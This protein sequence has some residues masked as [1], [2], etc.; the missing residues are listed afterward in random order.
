MDNEFSRE[1]FAQN[2]TLAGVGYLVF[3]VPL[4]WCGKSRLGRYCANQGLLLMIVQLLV[5]ILFTIFAGI[6]LLGWLFT[7]AGR[8]VSLALVVVALLCMIQVMNNERVT[9]LPYIGG[10]RLI[11]D[12]PEEE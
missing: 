5:N 4:I 2:K 9:E 3:F 10:V 1:D 6:P 11:P 12:I 8:L 7:L